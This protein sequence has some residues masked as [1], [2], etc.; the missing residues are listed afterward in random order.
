MKKI[1]VLT[2]ALIFLVSSVSFAAENKSWIQRIKEKFRKK[3]VVSAKKQLPAREVKKP[4]PPRK[5][6]KDMTMS[7]LAEDI[8]DNLD[9]EDSI[10]NMV[11]GL[12]KKSDPDG[13]EYYT[14][15]G[16][17][18]QDLDRDTLD[19]VFGRVRSEAL[20]IRTD[21]INRQLETIRGANRAIVSIPQPPPRAQV[22]PPAAPPSQAQRIPQPPQRPPA[23][24]SPTRR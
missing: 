8:T 14:Y 6:R 7:E 10:L 16:T 24:P 17:R 1:S 3:E 20:R 12:E 19:K 21:N 18:L 23:P 5:E 22:A 15:Q 13:K 2:L 4:E 11:P 9:R